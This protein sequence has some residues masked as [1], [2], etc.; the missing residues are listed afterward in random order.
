M[1]TRFEDQPPE[2]WAGPESL[3][4]TPVWKQFLL[5]GLLLLG[6]IA[7]VVVVSAAALAPLVVT[8]PA[9]MPGE[10]LVLR[11]SDVPAVGAPPRR[12]GAPLVDEARAFWIVRPN[13]T[14]AFAFR[15]TWSASVGGAQCAVDLDRTGNV[16]VPGSSGNI[17]PLTAP[18]GDMNA[19]PLFDLTGAPIAGARRGL[20]RYLVSVRD[21]RVIVNLGRLISAPEHASAP[22]A[23]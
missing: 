3:D 19:T 21:D 7:L 23:P 6:A 17:P 4:P 22:K 11:P 18:C 15:A 20:D 10:R 12:I 5:V 13:R 16:A 2:H 8:P 9:L 1:G 14:D